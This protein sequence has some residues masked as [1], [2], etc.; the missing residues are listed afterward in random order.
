MALMGGVLVVAA[1]TSP[2]PATPDDTFGAEC[3]S[4]APD[5]E[6]PFFSTSESYP[7]RDVLDWER[8]DPGD[9]G[10]DASVLE[11]AASD[12][13]LS[14]D[15]ASLLV[16]R[17]GK[18]AFERYFNGSGASEANN[19]HSLSKSIL[20]LL[21]GIAI[22]DGVLEL[23]TEI[24]TVLPADLVGDHGDLAVRD[25]LT[26][27]GGSDL[28]NPES[29]YEW[30]PSTRPGEPSFVRAVL[31]RPAVAE[32]GTE[33][34]YSTGLTQVLSA[35]LTEATGES[36]CEFA[37]RRLFGPLGID[38]EEWWVEPGGYF[39]GGHDLFITPRE[40]AAPRSARPTRRDMGWSGAPS[41]CVARHLAGRALGPR[42]HARRPTGRT[43][44]LRLPLVAHR[45][46]WPRSLE[47]VG[48]RRTGACP[49]R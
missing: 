4:F 36:L 38:V 39:A 17:D 6:H 33:F 44:G 25:L 34:E 1:C 20:S 29:N 18:L 42:V 21:A 43:T 12:A 24:G 32:A 41:G 45:D 14:A 40:V 37:A 48:G 22:D 13:A 47:G 27:S 35:V 8:V 30:E 28:P 31:E 23:D 5:P 7:D 9:V 19:V 3:A 10:F 46:R 26:M 16:V 15:L 11:T 49:G 2:D